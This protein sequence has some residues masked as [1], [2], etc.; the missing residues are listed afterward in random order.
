MFKV[1]R[2]C[3]TER[4]RA[5][6]RAYSP[7]MWLL[8]PDWYGSCLGPGDHWRRHIQGVACGFLPFWYASVRLLHL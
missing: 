8:C 1:G 6:T 4:Y 3:K 2:L 7:K 5:G